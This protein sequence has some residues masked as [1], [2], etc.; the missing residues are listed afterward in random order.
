MIQKKKI[1]E[2][3]FS[4]P[5][6]SLEDSSIDILQCTIFFLPEPLFPNKVVHLPEFFIEMIKY[7]KLG[8]E[9]SL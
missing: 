5:L 8:E 7:S 9:S 4:Y 1:N 3:K 2:A 6:I